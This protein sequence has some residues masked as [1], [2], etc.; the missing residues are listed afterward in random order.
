MSSSAG[1]IISDSCLTITYYLYVMFQLYL[2]VVTLEDTLT[3]N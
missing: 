3:W 1:T 2:L